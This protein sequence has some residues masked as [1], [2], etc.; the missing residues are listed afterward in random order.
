VPLIAYFD[1]VSGISGD[2]V[3][4]ALIDAGLGIERLRDQLASLQVS[5]YALRSE[6]VLRAGIAATRLHVELDGGEQPHRKLS[7]VIAIIEASTLPLR[8]KQ[9]GIAV[10]RRLAEVEAAIHGTGVEEIHF[11]EVGALDAIVDVMGAIIGLRL[12]GVQE[13]YASALPAGS[14]RVRSAHGT[15]PVP[16]PATLELLARA[17]ATLR[18]DAGEQGEL[19]TPTG[20]AL[21]AEL[22]RFERPELRLHRIGYGAGGRD[23]AGFPN[24]LRLWLGEAAGEPGRPLLQI[25]TNIDDMPAEHFGYVQERLFAAGALDVWFM[26]VQM[27]KNRPATVLALLCPPDAE[28]ALSEILLRETTTLGLRVWEVRRHEAERESLRFNSTLGEAAIKVKRLPGTAPRVAPEYDSC[29]EIALRSGLP[30]PEVFTRI[31]R[32]A[33]AWLAERAP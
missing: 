23:T 4:G 10:F 27:K 7:D 11:H 9:R 31:A 30:F 6:R 13:C 32:E 1:C 19:V 33:E 3:L 21:L 26:P 5:G 8:D 12:L 24:V 16:A 25:E 29:R 14:G 22:A 17:G 28:T 2:M 15:I 20:A 18:A